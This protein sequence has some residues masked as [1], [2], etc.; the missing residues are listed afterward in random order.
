MWLNSFFEKPL[1]CNETIVFVD[2]SNLIYRNL[3]Y[4]RSEIEK[5]QTSYDSLFVTEDMKVKKFND[6]MNFWKHVMVNSLLDCIKTDQP[7][8]MII[9]FDI[10]SYWRKDLFPEYK[11][12]R[13]KDE[14]FDWDSFYAVAENFYA[15]LEEHF[16]GVYFI[17]VPRCEADDVIAVLVKKLSRNSENKIMIV[18]SDKDYMQ[19]QKYANVKQRDPILKRDIISINPKIDL[20]IKI[21]ASGGQ[22]NIPSVKIKSKTTANLKSV[23]PKTATDILNEG[24]ETYLQ[25][26]RFKIEYM[27]NKKLID[28]EEIPVEYSEQ[29]LEAYDKYQTK[30]WDINKI[31]YWLVSEKL[32]QISS[33]IQGYS[34][35]LKKIK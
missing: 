8:K 34:S 25:D 24:L 1:E 28:F 18:S 6:V 12:N 35:L 20:E 13:K 26:E 2:I 32:V 17:K 9:A 16:S 21:L 29:I 31:W 5:N 15:G 33:E 22:D 11:A 30:E 27:R 3:F 10:K 14:D 23:G 4:A 7:T 19:L